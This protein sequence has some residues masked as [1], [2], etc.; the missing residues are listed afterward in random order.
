MSLMAQKPALRCLV[1]QLQAQGAEER[2][3]NRVQPLPARSQKV[4][5]LAVVLRHY[6]QQYQ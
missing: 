4:R 5:L 2:R 6:Q 3:P 1:L